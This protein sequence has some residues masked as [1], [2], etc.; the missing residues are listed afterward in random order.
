[1]T[2]VKNNLRWKAAV[3]FGR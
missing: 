2:A 1:M 3:I